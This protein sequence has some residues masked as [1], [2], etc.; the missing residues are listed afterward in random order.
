MRLSRPSRWWYDGDGGGCRNGAPQRWWCAVGVLAA[1]WS[2]V[3]RRQARCAPCVMIIRTRD[4][5]QDVTKSGRADCTPGR[6]VRIQA[7]CRWW[8]EWGCEWGR[9][10]TTAYTAH[11]SLA[12]THRNVCHNLE[13]DAAARVGSSTAGV[14]SETVVKGEHPETDSGEG[15]LT[16]LHGARHGCAACHTWQVPACPEHMRRM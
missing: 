10:P 5:N 16:L 14:H 4:E 12:Y 13:C 2:A 6:P 9:V 8:G 7:G 15:G 11:A 1:A 3:A